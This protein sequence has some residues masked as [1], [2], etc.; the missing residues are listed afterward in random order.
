MRAPRPP[1]RRDPRRPARRPRRPGP[2]GRVAR[3][4]APARRPSSRW[5]CSTSR[6][7]ATGASSCSNRGAWRRAPRPGGWPSSPARPSAGWSATRPATSATSAPAT[8]IEVVTE[9][10]LT[11]RLQQDPELPGVGL[12]VFD[13]VHERNLTTDLGLALTPRRGG[14]A[15][16]RPA[17]RGD[18]GDRRHGAV[19]PPAGDGRRSG[20]DRRE[21]RA[22][23]TRSTSAGC[24]GAATSA[25]SRPSSPRS[26]GRSPRSPA[27]CSC[28]CPASARSPASPTPS[29]APS[30][31][32]STSAASPAR[33]RSRSRTSPWRRHRPGRRRVVLATDIAETSLTVEGVRVVVDSGLGPG[34]ALRRRHRDDP[35]DDGVDQPRLRRPARRAGRAR[36]AR[37]R[38][39][40]VEPDGARHPAGPPGG[41]DHPGRPRRAGARAGGVGHAGRASCRSST[42][43][44][45]KAR[46]QAVELLGALGALDG[47]GRDHRRSAGGWSGCP[48]TR[49]WPA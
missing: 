17:H 19:R 35:A 13:E 3:R 23:A 40:A 36:R 16:A 11:R 8:R 12:V 43:R 2:G 10:V 29:P 28:S 47:A 37:R 6:G 31:P 39:P 21:H 44:R 32:T 27:T 18:V 45:P 42:R 22:D 14:D 34:T 1:D 48:C 4:R 25:S 20:A 24:R 26:G 5:R 33:W 46:R 7:S 30:A 49:G 9:G 15:A 38:L 41:R